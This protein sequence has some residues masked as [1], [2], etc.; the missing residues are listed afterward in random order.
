M[1]KTIN[2]LGSI[3]PNELRD[4]IRYFLTRTDSIPTNKEFTEEE[5]YSLWG[6]RKELNR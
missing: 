2:G 6:C 5:S 4:I 1:V 3:E